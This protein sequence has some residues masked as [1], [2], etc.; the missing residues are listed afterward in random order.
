MIHRMLRDTYVGITAWEA[1]EYQILKYALVHDVGESVTGD[2]VRPFKYATPEMKRAADEAEDILT[3]RLMPDVVK[4]IIGEL[5]DPRNTTYADYVKD[6][7]KAADFLCV[8]VFMNREFLHG[9][10]E[11][12]PFRK[13]MVADMT[14]MAA[15][16]GSSPGAHVKEISRLYTLMASQST[17]KFVDR[18]I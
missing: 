9:N 10:Q 8:Y 6:V 12:E 2:V 13:R 15:K 14:A 1:V 11:I 18:E 3:Q 17:R 4:Q 7:I 5:D 16:L